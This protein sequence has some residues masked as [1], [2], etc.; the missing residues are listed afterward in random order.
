VSN[1]NAYRY[2]NNGFIGNTA[3]MDG[4]TAFNLNSSHSF[5]MPKKWSG[6]LSFYYNSAQQ[7]AYAYARSTWS[8]NAGVQK[9]TKDGKA[10][11][12]LNVTDIFRTTFPRVTSSFILYEQY[13]TA[14]RDSRALNLSLI[15]RFGKNTVQ[16]ARRRT[17]GVE[18]EKN[19]AN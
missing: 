11:M 15:Y 17:T 14:F 12:R 9:T 5:T 1:L 19:R 18:E 6:E 4:N 8:L 2:N 13:F 10:T 16:A 3:A 7:V